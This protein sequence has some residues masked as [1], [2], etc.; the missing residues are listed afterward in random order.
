MSGVRERERGRETTDPLPRGKGQYRWSSAPGGKRRRRW[1]RQKPYDPTRKRRCLSRPGRCRVD[2]DYSDLWSK[3]A[4]GSRRWRCAGG[5]GV[6]AVVG[7][8]RR[9]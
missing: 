9:R 7:A 3:P 4:A 1:R 6:K 5:C 8:G 2:V